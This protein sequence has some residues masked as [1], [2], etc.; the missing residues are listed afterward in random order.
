MRLWGI[1]LGVILRLGFVG[2]IAAVGVMSLSAPAYAQASGGGEGAA[3]DAGG[4]GSAGSAG[5]AAEPSYEVGIQ[6]G[7]LLPD[8]IEG[9]TEIQ[10]LGGIRAGMRLAPRSYFEMGFITGNGEGQQWKNLHADLRMDMP[11]ENI[12]GIAYVGADTVYY[13]GH[14]GGGQ[15]IA[16]GGH[17]GGGVMAH[18]SGLTWFRADMKFGF[19][20]G[21]SLYIAA[22]FVWRLGGGEAGG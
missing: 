6:L 21:T 7:K 11:V 13:R 15:K 5:S 17:L 9:V 1:F 10:G 8:Q 2:A 14:N 4:A 20:P 16:F 3:A 22:G 12:I 19:S 18:I